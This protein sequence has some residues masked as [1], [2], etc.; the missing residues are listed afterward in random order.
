[1]HRK[2][3]PFLALILH[4]VL[5]IYCDTPL[6]ECYHSEL[7]EGGTKLLCFNI[8][9]EIP[10]NY[11]FPN[12]T[13]MFIFKAELT[14]IAANFF[15]NFTKHQIQMLTVSHGNLST[16]DDTS[17][18]SL[19][20]LRH[21][22]LSF[23]KISNISENALQKNDKLKSISLMWNEIEQLK[24]AL[25]KTLV[26]VESIDLTRN[27]LKRLEEHLLL[28]NQNLKFFDVKFNNLVEISSVM[29]HHLPKLTTLD[30]SFNHIEKIPSHVFKYNFCLKEL[31]LQE[32]KIKTVDFG[33]THLGLSALNL[34]GNPLDMQNQK[35]HDVLRQ[36]KR[37]NMVLRVNGHFD[38]DT[39]KHTKHK[40]ISSNEYSDHKHKKSQHVFQ[41][42]A[43]LQFI[44]GTIIA[45]LIIILVVLST[46]LYYIYIR[47]RQNIYKRYYPERARSNEYLQEEE[48]D[49]RL[50]ISDGNAFFRNNMEEIEMDDH[51]EKCSCSTCFTK[52]GRTVDT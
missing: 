24:P 30:L 27:H 26:D 12:V 41:T 10:S 44:F 7:E 28:Y 4:C 42:S 52:H 31:N 43:A 19:S 17:L 46:L 6:E 23:N 36:L 48:F 34:L 25:F 45:L 14:T 39:S 11:T 49:I 38:D 1:M 32:N 3:L 2:W 20:G 29:F 16:V 22:N 15:D 47:K 8:Q 35:N 51:N 50:S 40:N 5:L 37:S 33:L 21:L 18:D 13:Q 9:K